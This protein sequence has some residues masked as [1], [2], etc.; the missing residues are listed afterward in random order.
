MTTI[1]TKKLEKREVAREVNP[2]LVAIEKLTVLSGSLVEQMKALSSD[3]DNLKD[4]VAQVASR[5]GL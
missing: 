1:K 2:S 3:M 4:R 5:L